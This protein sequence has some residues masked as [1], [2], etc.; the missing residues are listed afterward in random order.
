MSK[1]YFSFQ[2]R[3][4]WGT[5]GLLAGGLLGFLLS[6]GLHRRSDKDFKVSSPS[7]V[8]PESS[9]ALPSRRLE[10]M[11]RSGTQ[12]WGLDRKEIEWA[13]TQ[14]E[15]IFNTESAR[16]TRR[17][18]DWSSEIVQKVLKQYVQP[19]GFPSGG[20]EIA[21][22]PSGSILEKRGFKQGDIIRSV[23]GKPVRS[24]M[25]LLTHFESLRFGDESVLRM[26]LDRAGELLIVEFRD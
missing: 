6:E 15:N 17:E 8:G 18:D 22:I 10:L 20:F 1:W 23:N 11:E 7:T 3:W 19:V 24:R 13:S 14:A 21:S 25:D 9:N 4:F 26:V 12:T 2:Q 16:S 5:I